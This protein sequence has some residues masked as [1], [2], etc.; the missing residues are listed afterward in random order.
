MIGEKRGSERKDGGGVGDGQVFKEQEFAKTKGQYQ[1]QYNGEYS[2]CCSR[3]HITCSPIF[4]GRIQKITFLSLLVN[5]LG[6]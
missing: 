1:D 6:I 4:G 5:R 3:P 2:N